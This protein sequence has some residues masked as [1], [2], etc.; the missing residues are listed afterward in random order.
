MHCWALVLLR[1]PESF[2]PESKKTAL[3]SVL[4]CLERDRSISRSSLHSLYSRPMY[5]LPSPSLSPHPQG[6]KL[7]P[8]NFFFFK[9]EE[10]CDRI[11]DLIAPLSISQQSKGTSSAKCVA[12]W[13]ADCVFDSS[14]AD[15]DPDFSEEGRY[16]IQHFARHY[17]CDVLSWM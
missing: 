12:H 5:S 11:C 8:P 10:I 1:N 9:I 14:N 6:K 13:I 16:T 7:P 15:D 3:T 17:S 2:H 4:P